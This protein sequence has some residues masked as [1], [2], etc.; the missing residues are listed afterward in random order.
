MTCIIQII[1]SCPFK[2]CLF[3]KHFIY[4]WILK[5]VI[6]RDQGMQGNTWFCSTTCSIFTVNYIIVFQVIL[7][8]ATQQLWWEKKS[9][10]DK[11]K[12]GKSQIFRA[13]DIVIKSHGSIMDHNILHGV[14]TANRHMGVLSWLEE[15]HCGCLCS[16]ARPPVVLRFLHSSFPSSSSLP[17]YSSSSPFLHRITLWSSHYPI[18][19]LFILLVCVMCTCWSVDV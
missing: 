15:R 7:C 5:Q 3:F 12:P 6:I 13:T 8:P 14:I 4:W 11:S 18:V 1:V 9:K 19:P 17:A 2:R 16:Q 10:K